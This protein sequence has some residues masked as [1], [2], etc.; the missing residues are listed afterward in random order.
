MA[1]KYVLRDM[2]DEEIK[3]LHFQHH[4]W[5][6]ET[7]TAI[8]KANILPGDRILDL[9]C[10]P[11]YLC[12]DLLNK[13]GPKGAIYGLDS[14][15]KFIHFLDQQ[16]IPN[17][18]PIQADIRDGFS[19]KHTDLAALHHVF[20]R[21]V[22]IFL[23]ASDS[24]IKNIFD[25]LKPGGK[26]VSLEYFD[27]NKIAMSPPTP[28]FDRVFEAVY[29]LLIRA[30]GDP[31]V[32]GKMADRMEAIGFRNIETIPIQ[33]SG[34]ANSPYWQ[35]MEQTNHNHKNLVDSGL[36]TQKELDLFYTDWKRNASIEN[37]YVTSP[38]LMITTGEK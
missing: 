30:G 6:T 33:K 7:Q 27:F 31:D 26:F 24:V 16:H 36:I 18:H 15:E 17:V 5:Q 28:S 25:V 19:N 37:A 14:S 11:G 9:G 35:L 22:F 1:H 4:V 13:V 12:M 32:G 8:D 20:C 29:E 34:T 3:R 38:P 23:G 10:G 21:W 2:D